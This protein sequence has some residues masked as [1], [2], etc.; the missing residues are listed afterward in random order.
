VT[1]AFFNDEEPELLL[2][3]TK[4]QKRLY[5]RLYVSM[6]DF[7]HASSCAS[8]LLKK[9]WHNAP[10]ER[11]GSVYFQQSAFTSSMVNAYG[12]PFTSYKDKW[13]AYL[14]KLLQYSEA[15][16]LLHRT[17][18][19]LRNQVYAHSDLRLVNIRPWR[20]ENFETDIIGQ[21]F[22]RVSKPDCQQIVSIASRASL[23]L[24]GEKR[25]IVQ[26]VE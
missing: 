5:T 19:D 21:P 4:P 23:V 10:W 18:I 24:A 16:L 13:E 17:L 1:E 9:G 2:E 15:E 8:H 22:L 12:R 26:K 25:R 7:Q 20:A 6:C 14:L 11:R 3:L